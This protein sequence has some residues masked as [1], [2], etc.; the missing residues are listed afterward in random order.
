MV[1]ISE[2][3]GQMHRS[4]CVSDNTVSQLVAWFWLTEARASGV[5][6]V[7]CITFKL[8]SWFR[9]AVQIQ[10]LNGTPQDPCSPQS[11]RGSLGNEILSLDF[12]GIVWNESLWINPLRPGCQGLTGRQHVGLVPPEPT[13][14]VLT[15]HPSL[16][17]HLHT[18]KLSQKHPFFP[19]THWATYG[20]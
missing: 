7:T 1:F 5:W 10:T 16:Q 13:L 15:T 20:I 2:K 4:F 17:E 3:Q 6:C 12:K 8:W 14:T 9:A 18:T 11:Y 19:S